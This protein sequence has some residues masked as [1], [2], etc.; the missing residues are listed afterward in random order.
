LP[1]PRLPQRKVKVGLKNLLPFI[2]PG[3][4]TSL[5]TSGSGPR[6]RP[7]GFALIRFGGNAWMVGLLPYAML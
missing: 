6:Y 2:S 1:R 7:G 3:I 5:R 4:K